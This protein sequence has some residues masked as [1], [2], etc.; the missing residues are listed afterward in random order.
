M[1]IKIFFCCKYD[2]EMLKL[3]IMLGDVYMNNKK[4]FTI[5]ELL[6]VILIISILLIIAAPT[7]MKYMKK[8][9]QS[10]YRSLESEVKVAGGEYVETYRSLLPQNI[11]HVRVV[12]LAELESNKYIDPVKDEK[13]NSCIGQVT[14][15]KTKTDSYDYYSCIKCG[16]YYTST[17]KYCVYND[18]LGKFENGELDNVYTDTGDYEIRVEKD[19]YEVEQTKEFISPLAEV[20]YKGELL[21]SDLEGTPREVNTNELGTYDVVYYYRGA[22]KIIKV[23]VVD[24]ELP[25]KT[26][27]V[28]KYNDKNGKS[29]Q[30]N[31]YS[32]DIYVKYKA[33]DYTVSRIKGSGID[34]YEVSNDGVNFV[35]VTK[36]DSRKYTPLS[37]TEQKMVVEGNYLRYVRAVDKNGNVGPVNSYRVKIDKTKP[38]CTFSGESTEWQPNLNLPAS[39]RVTSRTIVATCHDSISNCTEA[40]KSKTWVETGTNKT[41]TL[42]YTI[43][44][45]AGN[46]QVCTKNVNLYLDK[47]K[48]TITASDKALGT[49][50]YNFVDNV[51]TT[52]GPSGCSV[53]C[54]PATSRKTGT[55]QVT[56][57]ITSTVGLTDSVT[58]RAKHQYQVGGHS[59]TG[60]ICG[61]HDCNCGN[62]CNCARVSCDPWVC[63][64]W[65]ACCP[66]ANTCGCSCHQLTGLS[67]CGCAETYGCDRCDNTC[68]VYTCTDEAR[69]ADGSRDSTGDSWCYY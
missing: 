59:V 61:S 1:S 19:L 39:Q 12:D 14:I 50:D 43:I 60:G 66:S 45:L 16:D 7:V 42:A 26:Q 10:Y 4:G 28:L 54:D 6:A 20:Y 44:D 56:C 68:T 11:G 13:G 30:G 65:A 25:S 15:E 67:C 64:N 58:F 36:D 18:S 40:T 62:K 41:K 51:K 63:D 22:K 8:G 37:A 29:Y 27:V 32:G 52:C 23:K 38:T 3:Y 34:Y 9:T 57:T 69:H 49:Q 35:K 21:K 48:P 17:G 24:N 2:F 46:S 33:T 53:V 47:Q 31:W 55:Y 5:I